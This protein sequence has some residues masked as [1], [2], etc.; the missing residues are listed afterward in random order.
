MLDRELEKAG[1]SFSSLDGRHIG[2]YQRLKAEDEL[3]AAL[4]RR[5]R[6]P[7]PKNLQQNLTK[8]YNKHHHHHYHHFHY[9]ICAR[10][11]G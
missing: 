6:D 8:Q 1:F 4:L 2:T 7:E 10:N 3:H 5:A 9:Q 11:A